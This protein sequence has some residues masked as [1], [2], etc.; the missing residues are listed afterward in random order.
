MKLQKISIKLTLLTYY[1]GPST[2]GGGTF[3]FKRQWGA[4]PH[5]MV[6]EYW[7]RDGRAVPD[8]S[9]ANPAYSFAIRA[10]QRLP[11]TVTNA[12]GPAIVRNIP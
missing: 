7:S 8:I 5:Q 10:W 1:Y 11:V 4:E 2:P 12:I 9:P 6:W 3:H